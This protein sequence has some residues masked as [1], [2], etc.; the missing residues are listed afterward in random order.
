MGTA[1]LKPPKI[2]HVNWFRQNADGKFIWP[3]RR[4]HARAWLAVDHRPAARPSRSPIGMLPTVDA[5]DRTGIDVDD[6]TMQELVSVSKD[7]WKKEVEGVGEFFAKFGD[8][9]PAE[10]ERQRNALAKRL[11]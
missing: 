7:D 4:E 2:F 3:G 11:G 5:I 6:A 9:L 1:V 8:R 10:M